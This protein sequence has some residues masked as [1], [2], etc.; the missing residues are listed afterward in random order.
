VYVV[1]MADTE[2]VARAHFEAFDAVRPASTLVQV[3]ALTPA[4]ARVEIEVT[5]I[6]SD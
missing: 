3:G 4:S 2:R 1:D 5:A 6:I